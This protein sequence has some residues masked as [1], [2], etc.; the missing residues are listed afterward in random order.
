[1][2][3]F[4]L[5][6]AL[7]FITLVTVLAATDVSA[8][9]LTLARAGR[10]DYVIVIASNAPPATRFAAEE[11][12]RFLGEMSSA[13]LPV[14]TD[15]AAPAARQIL[16]GDSAHLRALGGVV[17]FA[18]LGREG[19]VLR[20]VGPHL[21]IAGGEP[22]GTLYGV[23]GLLEDHLGCRWFT[24]QVSHIP[25]RDTVRLGPLNETR[26]PVLEYREPFTADC[27][28]GTWCARNRVNSSAAS[29]EA[30]HGGKVRF[31]AGLF[32][33]TFDTL[34][35]P[36]KY[37][38]AHPEYFS[39]VN[40]VRVRERTQ[41]CCTHEEVV[42]LCTEAMRDRMRAD[43]EAEVYS[44][45]QNDWANYCTCP[46]CAA[47][48]E[49]EESQM[50]PV[51]QLVNRVAEALEA[52]FPDKAIE[53]LAYQWTRKAPKTIRPRRNVIVR[54][55]TI[56]CC[57]MHPLATCDSPAN[58]A[59]R[60]DIADWARVADRLWVWDYVTSF[61]HYLV[62]FPN[63][64]VRDDNI[65]F[66]VAHNVR[67]IFEQDVYN[68][69]H[70]ELSALSGYLNAKLL[71]NPAY[72]EERAINEFLRG[73]YG[74][75][76]RPIRRYLDLL[77]DTVARQN[78]HADI[79]IGPTDAP[80]LSDALLARADA[81]WAEA[82]RR[83]AR[84]PDVLARVQ[85]AR[86]SVDYAILERQRAF[87]YRLN[88]DAF[89][90]ELQPEFVER[91]ERFLR[92]ARRAGL[93]RLD[94]SR[95]TLDA[96]EQGLRDILARPIQALAPRSPN[97]LALEKVR[98]GLEYAYYEGTWKRLPNFATLPP[99]RTGVIKQPGLSLP[100][101]EESFGLRLRGYL[102]IPQ[103]GVYCFLLGSNDGSRLR[104]GGEVLI[105]NDDLHKF[106]EKSG[107][108]AVRAGFYPIE[109]EYFQAGGSA[110]LSLQVLGPKLTKQPVPAAWLFHQ[111][112]R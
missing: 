27:F 81:L 64:R 73:V 98:P 102:R 25:R 111:A 94:E 74:A 105:D 78:L 61:S 26:V 22:R 52:E 84:Q 11:L 36:E 71:W 37:F 29:L 68:T 12:Q 82:E 15:A 39:E 18:A 40:G 83:V 75:A 53:T 2:K 87:P 21:V 108:V 106:V 88:A 14:R 41:L 54:L 99:V 112:E 100:R 46:R 90:L 95:T 3:T 1:M 38:D 93:T 51:L 110:A 50:A 9:R 31:G 8:Q 63:L 47:L 96:Y 13:T 33:H 45:S 79:W 91:A 55:C 80:Y 4:P 43:P 17:D 16:V 42:R 58:A 10:S 101:R 65:R 70:G 62:P 92:V 85:T 76:A 56:E 107:V 69:L 23:Y 48:A 35:P 59:F 77:H 30:H 19:Y 5:R 34:V 103:D 72:D 28:D 32:V 109:I 89:R 86:L 44:L 49:R 20:T 57:F 97:P 67:G 104:F 66:F 60:R 7:M 6:A 24:P